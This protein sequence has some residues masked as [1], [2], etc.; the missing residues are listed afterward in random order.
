MEKKRKDI[1]DLAERL[2]WISQ[3]IN[4]MEIELSEDFVYTPEGRKEI[5]TITDVLYYEA[6]YG[7][8]IY[9]TIR[10]F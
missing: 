8:E 2:T 9:K 5:K 7:K 4:I 1:T 3:E 6:L 10:R